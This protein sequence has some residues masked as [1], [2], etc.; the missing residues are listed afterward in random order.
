[1]R[2]QNCD[3][4]PTPFAD[5]ERREFVDFGGGQPIHATLAYHWARMIE[6]L[7]A[8]EEIKD[9]LHDDDL[10]E[11][12]LV[13]TGPRH[14]RGVGVIEAP[15]G[16][17]IHHYRLNAQDQVMRANLIV[18]TT[19]NNHAMN[20]A[21]RQVAKRYLDGRTLTEGLLNHIEVAIRAFDPCLSCA[22][23]ALGQMPLEVEL[24]DA[25]GTRVG[26]LR[27]TGDGAVTSA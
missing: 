14:R 9:L 26:A 27:R 15:R 25:S 16:T 23:H 21:I 6:M 7:F 8:A 13:V 12:D 18:S 3:Q 17:L 2:V 19:H 20:Q 24:V 22:T 5:A 4:I 11:G 10:L 1:V